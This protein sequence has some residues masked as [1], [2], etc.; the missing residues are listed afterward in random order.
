MAH[1]WAP[2]VADDED[3]RDWFVWHMRRS[4]SPGAAVTAFRAAM[5]LDVRDVLAAVRVPTLM[6]R[7]SE[8]GRAYYLAARVRDAK[9]VELPSFPGIYT[10]IDDESHIAAI[11]ATTQFIRRHGKGTA[12]EQ[13][14]VTILF[15]VIVGSTELMARLGDATWG[16]IPTHRSSVVRPRDSPLPQRLPK[17]VDRAR[18]WKPRPSSEMPGATT[19]TG[20]I[21][22]PRCRVLPCQASQCPPTGPGTRLGTR[23][24]TTWSSTER[25]S[26]SSRITAR[27]S[28]RRARRP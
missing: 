20:S 27:E 10:W 7:P 16:S 2:E 1:E 18:S 24:W 26:G 8:P 5:E 12:N 23:S 22:T 25:P 21:C 19:T 11:E 3:F 15:T 14:L 17:Q 6:P 28:P 9:V 4:L 13:V